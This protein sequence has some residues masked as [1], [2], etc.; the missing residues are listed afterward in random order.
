MTV[1]NF[2]QDEATPHNNILIKNISSL[3]KINLWYAI[4]KSQ[5]YD[6]DV[7][8]TNEILKANVYGNKLSLKL[9]FY[10]FKYYNT[11]RFFMVG[12]SNPTTKVIFIISCILKI[13]L[14]MWFDLP[15]EARN[16]N[17]F[18]VNI[19]RFFYFLLRRSNIKIFCVGEITKEYFLSRGF[20]SSR[21]TNLPVQVEIA[22]GKKNNIT[23][24]T[25]NIFAGSRLT[26]D[27]G[28][29][30]LITALAA[31][32]TS[33]SIKLRLAGTGPEQDKLQLQAK[34]LGMTDTIEFVGWL[35]PKQ[36]QEELANC[37]VFVHPARVDAYG[38]TVLA[39]ASGTPV[40]GSNK[41][42]A[43]IDCLIDGVNGFTYSPESTEE[44]AQLIYRFYENR[45]LVLSFSVNA[46]RIANQHNGSYWADKVIEVMK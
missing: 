10:F 21:L 13:N 35:S 3:S 44:L 17:F 28:F 32:P 25:L 5:Q 33:A 4:D 12:W 37:D 26:Y 15:D 40:I 24:D 22:S 6:W 38:A 45:S 1:I 30:L 31:L 46:L 43:V 20:S 27:K 9:I 19:R 18:S 34:S 7:D 8:L 2:I 41:A 39:L 23:R 14:F 29:D 16:R 36:Y 11:E 42:G